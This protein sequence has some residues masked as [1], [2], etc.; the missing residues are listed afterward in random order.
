MTS[1]P[2]PGPNGGYAA[3]GQTIF[4]TSGAAARDFSPVDSLSLEESTHLPLA[5]SSHF[6]GNV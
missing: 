3:L 1:F 5:G 2:S 6:P 4:S